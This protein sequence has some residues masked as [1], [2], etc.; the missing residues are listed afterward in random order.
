M[1]FGDVVQFNENHKWYGSLGIIYEIKE[2]H[3]PELKCPDSNDIRFMVGVPAP[4]QGTAYIFVLESEFAIE[5]V[6][7]AKFVAKS[8]DYD[9]NN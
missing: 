9:K 7:E 6:G 2:V 8:D 5:K 1:K 3:N 4:L